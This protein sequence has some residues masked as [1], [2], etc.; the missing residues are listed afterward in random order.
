MRLSRRFDDDASRNGMVNAETM[1]AE[2]AKCW[3]DGA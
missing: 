1:L 2:L 3:K